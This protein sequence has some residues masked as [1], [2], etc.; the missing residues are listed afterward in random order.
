MRV[1]KICLRCGNPMANVNPCKRFC[2][3]CV[4]KRNREKGRERYQRQKARKQGISAMQ[5]RPPAKET[6]LKP[7]IKSI[8]QCVREATALGI[9][10]G[11]YVQ[12]GYDKE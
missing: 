4:S 1:D 6:Q 9:S 2:D 12:R 3:E 10:Y 8:N 7:R 5:D 11:Q